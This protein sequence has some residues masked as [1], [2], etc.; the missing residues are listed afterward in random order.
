MEESQPTLQ[1]KQLP[2]SKKV[3]KKKVALDK[4]EYLQLSAMMPEEKQGES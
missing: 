2:K 4:S 1:R 3:K